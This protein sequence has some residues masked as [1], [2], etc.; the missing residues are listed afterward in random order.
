MAKN[1]L[2]FTKAGI[3]CP[4]ADVYIDPNRQVPRAV[5]THAHADHARWGMKKYLAHKDSVP[6][7]QHRLGTK[8]DVMSAEYGQTVNA[9]GVKISLH[10]AGHIVGSAQIRLEYKGEVWVVS[11]DY[12]IQKDNVCEPFEA[13]PCH[14][15]ITEST[16]ALP[17][18]QWE[19]QDTVIGEIND[20]WR[21]N[22]DNGV[23]SVLSTYSLGKAQRV[24]Q[25]V[26]HTIGRVYAHGAVEKT[27][28]VLRKQ[29]IPLL[30]SW[31]MAKDIPKTDLRQGLILAP[32]SAID[33][34]WSKR[35]K[36]FSLGVASG[37]M[38]LGGARSR[39]SA[40]R[41]FVLSDHADW[42]GL[43]QAVEAT[44]AER[45]FV[46]HGFS[47]AFAKWLSEKGLNA[48]VFKTEPEIEL[49]DETS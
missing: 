3:Y 41:G 45:I 12:K 36:P 4:Q 6:I 19:P 35:L 5:I 37:W 30:P 26:D 43:N 23:A 20:W 2:E 16:F 48:D 21:A 38:A 9:N 14:T 44:G 34:Y 13:V 47:D 27:N 17:V 15:F 29:G 49:T 7:M 22:A 32:P 11:G 8:I 25:N 31:L 24:L 28:A 39:R 10:P 18:Y 46:T 1:L 40:D 42:N 33:S